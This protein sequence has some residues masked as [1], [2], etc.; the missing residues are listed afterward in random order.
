MP[1]NKKEKFLFTIIVV[2]I[3][4]P[5]FVTYCM[6]YENGGILNINFQEWWVY[7]CIE[8]VLAV[9]SAELLANPLA[10]KLATRAIDPQKHDPIIVTAAITCATALI[11]CLWMSLLATILYKAIVPNVVG[12]T[13]E[14]GSFLVGFIPMW[15]QAV[16]FNFPFA[17]MGQL[18]VIQPLSRTIFR[19]IVN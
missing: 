9:L 11:M 6:A 8:W 1:K 17:L 2:T 12:Q 14:I 15:L 4:I 3:T 16:V 7:A 18:F 13:W 10:E 5:C 19:K